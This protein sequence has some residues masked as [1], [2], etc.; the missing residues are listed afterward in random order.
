MKGQNTSTKGT[1]L[2]LFLS[3]H[4]DDGLFIFE[5]KEDLAD[6]AQ[7][8]Q[9]ME[10]QRP[11]SNDEKIIPHSNCGEHSAMGMQVTYHSSCRT[12]E[13]QSVP[14]H[15]GYEAD[16]LHIKMLASKEKTHQ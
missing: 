6:T 7:P 3:L 12:K 13:A 5:T 4:V 14:P 1:A 8:E 15:Q 11:V 2:N 16:T 9:P 10:E